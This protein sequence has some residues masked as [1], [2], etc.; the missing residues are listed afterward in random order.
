MP[1]GY[2]AFQLGDGPWHGY[3][4]GLILQVVEG[5]VVFNSIPGAPTYPMSSG[6]RIA[7]DSSR[8]PS[9]PD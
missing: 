8:S 6:N 7:T 3:W 4:Y 2:A 1:A 5:A 9:R